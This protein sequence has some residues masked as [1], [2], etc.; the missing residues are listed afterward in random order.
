MAYVEI[1]I[2]EGAENVMVGFPYLDGQYTDEEKPAENPEG[3]GWLI[4]V[5]LGDRQDTTT[6]QEQFLNSS[7]DV[8]EYAVKDDLDEI[9][10]G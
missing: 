10:E 8:L 6:A 7:D 3:E 5:N 4:L 9:I 1:L 2:R